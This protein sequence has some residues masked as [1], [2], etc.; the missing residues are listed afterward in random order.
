MLINANK[1]NGSFQFTF[2]LSSQH[3]LSCVCSL[4]QMC[5]CSTI[6][7]LLTTD[8][9]HHKL[10]LTSQFN[11]N[12]TAALNSDLCKWS[13]HYAVNHRKHLDMH[14]VT[15]TWWSVKGFC[16][17]LPFNPNVPDIDGCSPVNFLGVFCF[18]P[19]SEEKKSTGSTH[20]MKTHH[21]NM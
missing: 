12:L 15:N 14:I 20:T 3:L 2:W 17:N 19:G 6:A 16:W 8:T 9:W 18:R 10:S 7:R 5:L 13:I 4:I 11:L 21:G 1:M